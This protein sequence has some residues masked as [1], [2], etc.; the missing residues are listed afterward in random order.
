MA[1][2][3]RPSSNPN[4]LHADIWES[5]FDWEGWWMHDAYETL[6]NIAQEQFDRIG[7]LIARDDLR[8]AYEKNLAISTFNN[9]KNTGRK[10]NEAAQSLKADINEL[11]NDVSNYFSGNFDGV[12]DLKNGSPLPRRD[13]SNQY[14]VA[15][16]PIQLSQQIAGQQ[17]K[18]QD[19]VRAD[20]N[21]DKNDTTYILK[22]LGPDLLKH[23][24]TA[25]MLWENNDAGFLD[26]VDFSDYEREVMSKQGFAIRTCN[27]SIPHTI[28]QSFSVPVLGSEVQKIRSS[29]ETSHIATLS[30]RLD[31]NVAWIKNIN[32]LIGHNNTVDMKVLDEEL[33]EGIGR[34]N[35]RR[36]IMTVANGWS[37]SGNL[38]D[39]HNQLLVAI[40][41]NTRSAQPVYVF[42]DV[43]FTGINSSLT[44]N[45]DSPEP[46]TIPIEFVFKR[47][48]LLYIN[49]NN[50]VG[51]KI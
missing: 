13:K 21:S 10:I 46:Q 50:A 27:V 36:S 20:F 9:I 4:K 47:K 11:Q 5:S 22:S 25:Y 45:R 35:W 16:Y 17:Q 37:K 42:D 49:V 28:N 30:I 31:Q 38:K 34:T 14:M 6:E 19:A 1:S 41:T 7:G 24:F 40:E 29:K 8:I 32:R 33:F 3:K 15:Y 51:G 23:R 18:Q 43:R 44:Y 12:S 2:G 26:D 39:C 48:R